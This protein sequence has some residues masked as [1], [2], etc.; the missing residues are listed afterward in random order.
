MVILGANLKYTEFEFGY[1]SNP[2]VALNL[3]YW[4]DNFMK[5]DRPSVLP[6]K[7]LWHI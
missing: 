2:Y 3:E 7:N 6:L 4:V 1:C 5:V